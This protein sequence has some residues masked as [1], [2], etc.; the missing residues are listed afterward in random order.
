[1][2]SEGG[3]WEVE[4]A[5]ELFP[6]LPPLSLL[7]EPPFPLGVEGGSEAGGGTGVSPEEGLTFIDVRLRFGFSIPNTPSSE[8][9]GEAVWVSWSTMED[10]WSSFAVDGGIDEEEA[11]FVNFGLER[12]GY[13]DSRVDEMEAWWNLVPVDVRLL[14]I[15]RDEERMNMQ[16]EGREQ[17]SC[18]SDSP[19]PTPRHARPKRKKMTE[20]VLETTTS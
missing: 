11:R 5:E 3:S 17:A 16:A 13:L 1:M 7:P 15:D 20:V 14:V 18:R 6:P 10:G 4:A 12:P 8:G 2:F 19:V 9:G